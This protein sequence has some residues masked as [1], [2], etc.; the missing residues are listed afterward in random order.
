MNAREVLAEKGHLDGQK[1]RNK[2][3]RE[4][5][6]KED[7]VAWRRR[8]RDRTKTLEIRKIDSSGF[9]ANAAAER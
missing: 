7:E 1:E 6:W 4:E 5:E 2:E 8:V 9:V 3:R